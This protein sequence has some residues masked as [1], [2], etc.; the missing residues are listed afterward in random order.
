MR[1]AVQH[2]SHMTGSVIE[3]NK[4]VTQDQAAFNTVSHDYHILVIRNL[5]ETAFITFAALIMII[6]P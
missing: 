2:K 6:A 1:M 5:M 3:G 4:V